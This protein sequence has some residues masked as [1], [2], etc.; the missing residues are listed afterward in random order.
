MTHRF[1]VDYKP[2]ETLE[3]EV[4]LIRTKD[5]R[6]T[7]QGGLYI[8]AMLK[9]RTGEIVTRVWQATEAGFQA[10]PEGGFMRFK[11]RVENYKG[12]LQFIVDAMRPA[13]PG[14]YDLGD[15]L[16]ATKKDIPQ[17]FKR[18]TE[19]LG[20]LKNPALKAL[21]KDFLDDD[22]LMKAFRAAPAAAV[23][24]HAYIGGL[25][26]HTLSVLE[27]AE[28]VIPLYPRLSLDLV[29]MGVFLHDL[30]KTSEL[31]FETSISY[32]DSGQLL[33]HI[34][35]AVIWIEKRCDAVSGRMESPFP[36]ELKWALQHIV[37]SHH[38]KYE[39]GSPKLP[40]IPEAIAVHYLD[41]FDAKVHMFLASI[42]EDRDPVSHWT[43]FNRALESKVYKVDVMGTR[44]NQD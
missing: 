34:A 37:L 3:D 8:H 6:T 17:M 20:G 36:E 30:G 12:N 21:A 4:L 40:A 19:I 23:L 13:E 7:T 44:S 29:V 11:G 1:I 43:N 27:L 41:N 39:F 35:H 18:V 14:S 42:D 2:G 33:G 28:R 16:P 25:L 10:M 24:H 5:L 15:F 32:T 31:S 38:G 9:D 26:E 22:A